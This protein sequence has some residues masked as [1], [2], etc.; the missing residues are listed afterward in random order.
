MYAQVHGVYGY[1]AVLR[2]GL[3]LYKSKCATGLIS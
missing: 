3:I 2:V 1:A